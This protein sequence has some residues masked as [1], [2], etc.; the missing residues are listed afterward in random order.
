MHHA[1]IV[2]I[3]YMDRVGAEDARLIG[4]VCIHVAMPVEMILR[5]VQ[6]C[7][8]IGLQTVRGMQLKTRQF[9]N[10]RLRQ[11]VMFECIA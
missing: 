10:P 3:Q 6:D 11:C 2:A 9:Q 7:R 1:R 8:D 4:C 5:D